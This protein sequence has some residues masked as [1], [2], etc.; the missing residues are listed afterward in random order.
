MSYTVHEWLNLLLRWIH[1]FAGIMWVGATYY[2]TW[3]DRRFHTTDPDQ[4]WMVHSGGFYVV[5]K[6]TQP[7]S[8]H[9]LHW[10]KWE[11]A[12]TWLSG[13]PLLILVYYAGGLLTDGD[14]N[15][16]SFAVA[17]S[18]GI[19]ILLAGWI[20]YDLLWLSPLAKK[21]PL[22]VVIS[23]AL[24]LLLAWWLPQVMSSRAAFIHVGAVLGT[25]MTANVWMRILPAQRRLVAA[26]RDGLPPDPA[27]AE[28]A[29]F[30]SKH[31]TYMAVPVVFM[32]ISNHFPVTTYGHQWNWIILGGLTLGGWVVAHF[33]RKQ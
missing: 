12:M 20:V 1:V 31:N 9:T 16:P 22:A 28:R 11:A 4:V 23:F 21:E 25:L 14:P 2:F 27:L 33:I 8:G 13:V 6:E 30:R 29:K 10:F 24:I 32:M 19:G 26:V 3:L 18:I 17:A 5:N 7:A 15:K